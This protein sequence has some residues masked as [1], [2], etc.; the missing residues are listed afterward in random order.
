[1][2]IFISSDIEG[3]NG[4]CTWDE[5]EPDKRFYPYFAEKMSRE[6][7]AVCQGINDA[8]PQADILVKDAHHTARNIDHSLLP[9]NVRLNRGWSGHPYKMMAGIDD[10]YDASMVTGYHSGGGYGGNPLAHTMSMR[11]PYLKI[12]DMLGSEF[13]MNYYTSLYAGVP[14]VL[15]AGDKMLCEFAKSID[16]NIYTFATTKGFG[17]SVTGQ[18]PNVV[19][20]ALRQV[21]KEAVENRGKMNSKLPDHFKIE[22]RFKDHKEAY[23]A[24]FYPG[25]SLMDAHTI[26]YD[27]DDYYEF[28]RMFTFVF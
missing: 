20:K 28:L 16:P 1:M 27:T 19:N 12:N 15:V 14:M 9:E 17:A 10:S 7:A 3:T 25:I 2:K 8:D 13:L 5:T 21:A 18:H 4:V 24:S 26:L 22:M 23:K 6:V 11:V